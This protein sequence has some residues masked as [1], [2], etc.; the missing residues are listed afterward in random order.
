MKKLF[1][2]VLLFP[3]FMSAAEQQLSARDIHRQLRQFRDVINNPGTTE[4]G[5]RREITAIDNY[6]DSNL[7]RRFIQ[8]HPGM[9]GRFNALREF[10]Q[11]RLPQGHLPVEPQLEPGVGRELFPLD[12]TTTHF[13]VSGEPDLMD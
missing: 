3:M 12:P 1:L 13:S 9:R 11:G 6:E 2:L 10:A 4:E 5:I 8:M 7:V